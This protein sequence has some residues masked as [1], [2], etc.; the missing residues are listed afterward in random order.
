MARKK[1]DRARQQKPTRPAR[2][3]RAEPPPL[4]GDDDSPRHERRRGYQAFARGDYDA[5]IQAWTAAGRAGASA[6]LRA[7]L[8]EAHFRRAVTLAQRAP[9]RALDDMR[10]AYDFAPGDALYAYHLGLAHHRHGDLKAA[11]R[12]YQDCLAASPDDSLAARAAIMLCLA[13]AESG[14]DPARDPAWARLSPEQRDLLQPGDP[15]YIEALKL[16]AQGDLARAEPF[17]T[18]TLA[19]QRGFAHYYLGAAAWSRGDAEEAL[20]RWL[21]ARAAGFNTPALRQNLAAAYAARAARLSDAAE[22][23]ETVRAGLK[24]VPGSPLLTRQRARAAWLEGVQAADAGDWRAALNAWKAARTAL[25]SISA[26]VPRNLLANIAVAS[27]RLERWTDAAETWREIVRRRPRRGDE[28]WTPERIASLW[29]HIETLYARAGR[30]EQAATMLHYAIKAQPD[31]LT[32]RLALVRRRMENENW[33]AAQAAALG[34]LERAPGHPEATALYAQIADMQGDLDVAI[35]AWERVL[36]S[37]QKS[38]H[39]TARQRLLKLYAERGDFYRAIEDFGAAAA[40]FEKAA[41]LAPAESAVLFRAQQGAALAQRDRDAARAIFAGL[42][43]ARPDLA[44]IIVSA[45]HAAGDP[46]EAAHWLERATAA[47]ALTPAALVDLALAVWP[48]DA[49]AGE[50]YL[51]RAAASLDGAT[52]E[53]AAGLLTRIAAAYAANGRAREAETFARRALAVEAGYG[54]A[55]L[56]L[57]LWDAARGRRQAARDHLRRAAAWAQRLERTDMSDGI[58]EAIELLDDHYAPS[59]DEV[60]DGIDPDGVDA[61]MRRLLGSVQERAEWQHRR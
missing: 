54:P 16:L 45:W 21:S 9:D 47:R 2:T 41:A 11:R 19:A 43:P 26:P 34:I 7:A 58:Q 5:A 10:R 44:V 53:D 51:S 30:L 38:L 14:G 35:D 17:L 3:S 13:A 52:G 28:S 37:S 27:E 6:A 24:I 36:A 25:E 29:A 59:L 49:G 42:D 61:E 55:H 33:R 50:A 39:P 15:A 57:G 60:L 40:D 48:D 18:R 8:A 31:D 22:L 46:A 23:A 56:N 1:Q 20:A 12:A 32:L 4:P